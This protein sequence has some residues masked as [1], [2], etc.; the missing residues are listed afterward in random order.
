MKEETIKNLMNEG[1]RFGMKRSYGTIKQLVDKKVS[2]EEDKLFQ[3]VVSEIRAWE[4]VIVKAGEVADH[5]AEGET[6]YLLEMTVHTSRINLLCLT[7][8]LDRENE[9]LDGLVEFIRIKKEEVENIL[10]DID[11]NGITDQNMEGLI[12]NL[13]TYIPHYIT[14]LLRD[15]T[16]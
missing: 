16:R 9:Y 4:E 11:K 1:I 15:F 3:D 8:M 7:Y 5:H 10:E 14:E 13:V 2:L 12:L 6:K